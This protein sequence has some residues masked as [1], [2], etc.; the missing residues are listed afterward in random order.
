MPVPNPYIIHIELF[1]PNGTRPNQNEI[2]R[3][4]VF[5]SNWTWRGQ[6]GWNPS[7]GGWMD[8]VVQNAPPLADLATLRFRETSTAEQQVHQTGLYSASPNGSTMKII[9]GVSDELIQPVSPPFS[10]SGVD[11]NQSG[12]NVT[13]G[14]VE[15]SD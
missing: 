14:T 1:W 6:C 15:I 12:S 8:L 13:D 7:T 3:V 10:V 11:T 5:E 9:I 4:D 2:A